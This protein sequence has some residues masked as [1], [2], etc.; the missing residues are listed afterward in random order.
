MEM[1]SRSVFWAQKKRELYKETREQIKDI[2][3]PEQVEK[4]GKFRKG[5]K[6]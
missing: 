3:N 5:Q 2:L 1:K 4:M 6:S